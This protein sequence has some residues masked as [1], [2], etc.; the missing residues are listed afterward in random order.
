MITKMRQ[1]VKDSQDSRR[2]FGIEN[3]QT[4][5]SDIKNRQFS[6]T[7]LMKLSFEGVRKGVL[8]RI[9][10]GMSKAALPTFLTY[11][12]TNLCNSRC[13]MCGIWKNKKQDELSINKIKGIFDN[14]LFS[15]IRW[16]NLTG[17]EPFLRKDLVE[18]V[19]I[20]NMLPKLEGI[21]IPTNGLLTGNIVS[22]V[23]KILAVLNKKK[24]LSVTV[25]IDGTEATHD[26]I[27]GIE[28]GFKMSIATIKELAKI[29]NKNFNLGVETTIS[30]F[31]LDELMESYLYLKEI[32]PYVAY[33]IAF[34]SAGYFGN[35]S[36]GNIFVTAKDYPKIIK[37]LNILARYEPEHAFYYN[38]LIGILKDGNRKI[39]CLG[40]FK[41]IFMDQHGNLYPC[42]ILS[43]NKKYFI[44]NALD[45][46]I[47]KKWV[48]NN[49][50]R[51]NLK[52]E[53]ICK[54][55]SFSC[56]L[57]NN[58][59]EEF[60][61]FSMFLLKHPRVAFGLAKKLKKFKGSYF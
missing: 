14:A 60:L 22:T 25:S 32:V 45:D 26:K 48:G 43:G 24:F 16:I 15:K 2:I 7:K 9:R 42:A 20:L 37:F 40:G 4:K 51:K 10:Y 8:H 23:K 1:S 61:Q 50:L 36:S 28:G 27:R 12:L 52:K 19:K 17:G 21:A 49:A 56:D 31:N 18:A 3:C 30:K 11:Q 38:M 6:I 58:I 54:K 57:I 47:L 53:T 5:I 44:G 34:P 33:T 13:V 59:K 35:L 41:S 39:T 46:G 29:K 55:C